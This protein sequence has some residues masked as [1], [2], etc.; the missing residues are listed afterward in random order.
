MEVID[1]IIDTFRKNEIHAG[2]TLQKKILM[3]EIQK[4]DPSLKLQVRDAWH[5]LVGNGII[6]EQ[7]PIGPTLTDLGEQIIYGHK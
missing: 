6:V 1:I 5:T 7:N 2:E 3:A 4:L